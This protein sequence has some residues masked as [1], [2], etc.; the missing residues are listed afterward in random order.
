MFVFL[1]DYDVFQTVL[2]GIVFDC[3]S[4]STF[5]SHLLNSSKWVFNKINMK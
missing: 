2:V 1:N 5:L 4:H 3:M